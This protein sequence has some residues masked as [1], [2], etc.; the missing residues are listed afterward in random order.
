MT[1][2]YYALSFF[3]YGFFGWCVE[4]AYAA[5]KERR[6]VNRGFL[7][8]PICPIYGVGVCAVIY[9]LR[10]FTTNLLA[11]YIT[12]VVIVTVLE[13]LTGFLLEKLFHN[14][15]WDYSEMP[16]NLN[17]YVCLLFSMIWGVFCVVIVR[18]MNPLLQ[19]GLSFMPHILGGI[20]LVTL[21]IVLLIDLYITATGIQK[22]NKY[23]ANME[24]ITTELHRISEQIGTNI[25]K[26]VMET[27]EKQE[28]IT[29]ELKQQI[30]ELKA[31]YQELVSKQMAKYR[32]LLKAFPRMSS[33]RYKEALED[34]ANYFKRK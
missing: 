1:L 29:D 16:L 19:K 26:G 4:V 13:W 18:F 22:M 31:G 28:D 25:F 34:I 3:V 7:S 24:A 21:S 2:Y 11:L 32:R 14:K 30:V 5:V 27:I 17:G 23:L 10:P 8:G 20:L 15:W 33:K 9:F 6:F 12:S